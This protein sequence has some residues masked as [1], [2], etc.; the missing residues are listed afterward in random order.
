MCR[1]VQKFAKLLLTPL[2]KIMFI[3]LICF[4]CII[5]NNVVVQVMKSLTALNGKVEFLIAL[6]IYTDEGVL[7]VLG[8]EE[9][10]L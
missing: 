6:N 2:Y 10:C 7:M 9:Y 5:L 3:Q 1:E 8:D 4:L